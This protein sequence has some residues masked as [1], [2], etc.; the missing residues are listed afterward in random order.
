MADWVANTAVDTEASIKV[1]SFCEEVVVIED[2]DVFNKNLNYW[3]EASYTAKH[4][5][6][7]P[8]LTP[9]NL[10]ILRHDT[11]RRRST[12][13]GIS[14]PSLYISRY[15]GSF[16]F[17]LQ[18][19]GGRLCILKYLTFS[20]TYSAWSIFCVLVRIKR[21]R[22]RCFIVWTRTMVRRT[23]VYLTRI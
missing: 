22:Q 7:G 9:I 3:L 6:Q 17:R 8:A 20:L 23:N 1:P 16:V 5:L 21:S 19:I 10:T 13:R 12:V 14:L 2:S 18:D 15:R 4:E 11:A